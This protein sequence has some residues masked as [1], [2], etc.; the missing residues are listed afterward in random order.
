MEQKTFYWKVVLQ[1]CSKLRLEVARQHSSSAVTNSL[2]F[3][4]FLAFQLI[5]PAATNIRD[6]R[7]KGISRSSAMKPTWRLLD[8]N[9]NTFCSTTFQWNAFCPISVLLFLFFFFA[10]SHHS[11]Q[12]LHFW[13]CIDSWFLVAFLPPTPPAS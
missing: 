8:V 2:L 5:L 1:K 6:F 7:M 10:C 12:L 9:S 13:L 4:R 11:L 3:R